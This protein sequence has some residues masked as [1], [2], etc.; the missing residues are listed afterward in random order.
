[1]ARFGSSVSAIAL[2]ALLVVVA[3]GCGKSASPEE[4]W[5]SSVC[6]AFGDWKDQVQ[7]SGDAIAAQIR[8]PRQGMLT[9]IQSEAQSA[10][11]ATDKLVSDL[12]SLPP[13]NTDEG[14]KAKQELDALATQVESTV[15]EAKATVSNLP[16]S[17]GVTEIAKALSSLAPQ[18]ASLAN[19][20]SSAD[21][22]WDLMVVSMP[23]CGDWSSVLMPSTDVCI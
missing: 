22:A 2:A 23:C 10:I 12:K 11:D 16:A 4:K 5:A 9:A 7:K 8:S 1:M 13:L 18:F 15:N 21:C 19:Q 20:A 17:A 6:T 3:T 14:T